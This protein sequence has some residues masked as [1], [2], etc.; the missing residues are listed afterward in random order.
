[1]M[2]SF[3]TAVAL[4]WIV[5]AFHM[6]LSSPAKAPPPLI[7]RMP[8]TGPTCTLLPQGWPLVPRHAPMPDLTCEGRF[9][10]PLRAAFATF[11]TQPSNLA[12]PTSDEAPPF[13][14]TDLFII[15]HMRAHAFSTRVTPSPYFIWIHLNLCKLFSFFAR[16]FDYTYAWVNRVLAVSNN[17][18]ISIVILATPDVPK[19]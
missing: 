8:Q 4:L 5:A 10:Q 14:Y 2:P 15:T 19:R 11:L 16:Y 7:P 6:H 9:L 1:M 17:Q 13:T 18:Q 12:I 3:T